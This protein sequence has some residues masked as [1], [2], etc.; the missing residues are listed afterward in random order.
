M[1]V[2][3]C[4]HVCVFCTPQYP[5]NIWNKVTNFYKIWY[6]MPWRSPKHHTV[7]F[8]TVNNS[9]NNSMQTHKLVT[10]KWHETQSLKACTSSKNNFLRWELTTQLQCKHFVLMVIIHKLLEQNSEIWYKDL[11]QAPPNMIYKA[12]FV[13]KKITS[14]ATLWNPEVISD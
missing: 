8:P 10:S 3:V 6:T 4:V 9:N 12:Q 1:R 7:Q 14:M 13:I 2:L 5:F 11:S